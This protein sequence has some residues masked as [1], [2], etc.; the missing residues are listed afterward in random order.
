MV[1]LQSKYR[2]SLALFALTL[3][4]TGLALVQLGLVNNNLGPGTLLP[5]LVLVGCSGAAVYF[6]YFRQQPGDSATTGLLFMR[7]GFSFDCAAG[8]GFICHSPARLADY[9]YSLLA[10]G[11]CYSP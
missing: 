3:L 6:L 8:A 2:G 4:F 5:L 7:S 9:C 1:R 10:V 11:H